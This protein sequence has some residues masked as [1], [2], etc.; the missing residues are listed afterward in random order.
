MVFNVHVF[1]GTF[2]VEMFRC[3]IEDVQSKLLSHNGSVELQESIEKDPMIL[4]SIILHEIEL[5][6]TLICVDTYGNYV[7]QKIIEFLSIS[8]VYRF[9]KCIMNDFY[10]ISSSVPGSCVIT[11]LMHKSV[12]DVDCKLIILRALELHVSQLICDAQGSH[13]L[14]LAINLFEPSEID[15][16]YKTAVDNFYT[17]STDRFGCCLIKK[18]VEKQASIGQIFSLVMNYLFTLSN[19]I[20]TSQLIIHIYIFN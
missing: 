16:I 10:L 2:D 6:P 9:I 20:R 8:Q 12:E 4:P 14:Q 17:I 18:L 5:N 13:L 3:M 15:F 7:C 1:I 11:G 19:V